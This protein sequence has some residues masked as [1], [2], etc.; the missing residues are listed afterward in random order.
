MFGCF[1]ARCCWCYCDVMS[2]LGIVGVV[3]DNVVI[4]KMYVVMSKM[5]I[6]LIAFCCIVNSG[7]CR[8]YFYVMK[9]RIYN[10]EIKM[11][12]KYTIKCSIINMLLCSTALSQSANILNSLDLLQ[13]LTFIFITKFRNLALQMNRL[14]KY[15]ST[16]HGQESKFGKYARKNCQ[17]WP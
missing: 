9:W 7:C 17:R 11:S 3:V 5:L 14:T 4:S 10:I 13:K 6:L 2:M 12:C 15:R 1:C 16:I 8:L